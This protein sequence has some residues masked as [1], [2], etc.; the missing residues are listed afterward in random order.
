MTAPQTTPL[1]DPFNRPITYL[2]VSVTDRCDFR[3]VYCMSENMTFLPKRELLT[4]EELERVC[5][6]FVDMGV[7]KL[8]ITGGEPL[9]RRDIMTFFESMG[10]RI[11]SGLDELTLTTNGSQLRRFAQPLADCG[12][13]R[14]NISL[15]T[16]NEKKFA[17]ITRWGRFAQVLDGIDA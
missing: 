14:V 9:V 17:E 7:K 11:G 10:R 4:L 16:L 12:V 13:K 15:D 6:T 3:C 5:G 8:R 2:R 1:I